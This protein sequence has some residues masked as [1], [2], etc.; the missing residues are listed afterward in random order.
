MPNDVV[1]TM[2]FDFTCE[3]ETTAKSMRDEIV[4]FKAQQ[5]NSILS[6]LLSEKLE[7]TAVWK[8]NKIEIDLGNIRLDEIRSDRMLNAFREL[9]SKRIDE[10]SQERKMQLNTQNAIA[11]LRE[12]GY[13]QNATVSADR[14][15]TA[16][17]IRENGQDRNATAVSLGENQV[18]IIRELL[19]NGDL[20]WWVDKNDFTGIDHVMKTLINEYPE[21]LVSFLQAYRDKAGLAHRMRLLFSNATISK[22]NAILP[23]A[24]RIPPIGTFRI[25]PA[26]GAQIGKLSPKNIEKV[27]HSLDQRLSLRNEHLVALV[28]KKLLKVAGTN[29]LSP[30]KL[31]AVLNANELAALEMIL[32]KNHPLSSA[33]F[34]HTREILRR[35]SAVQLEFLSHW[36]SDAPVVAGP[37][38]RE[39]VARKKAVLH[40]IKS[41]QS[42]GP[43]LQQDLKKLPTRDLL[44]IQKILAAYQQPR[45]ARKKLISLLIEHPYFPRYDLLSLVTNLSLELPD[46]LVLSLQPANV[47]LA[48]WFT[49]SKQ[50]LEASQAA[51][52]KVISRLSK[53]EAIV[54]NEVFSK[55]SI[56]T[57]SARNAVKGVLEK[58]PE[59]CLLLMSVLV[60]LEKS[61]IE[62]LVERPVS[63][64]APS[65]GPR[66]MIVE[67]AGLCLVAPFLPSLF[68]QLGFI[69]NG[70]FKSDSHA[71]RAMHVLQ[72]LVNGRR[73]NYE[74]VMQL[75]RVLCGMDMEEP[76]TRS[77]K[78]LSVAE[79]NEADDLLNSVIEHWKVLKSTSPEGF[80][81]SFL[82]RKGLLY[83]EESQWKLQVEKKGYDLLLDSI[84]WSFKMIKF[85][86]MNKMMDVE[87]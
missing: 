41:L 71:R 75:N 54:L 39:T 24:T 3:T 37:A 9:L 12:N 13:D 5:F 68:D 40:I 76:V 62:K 25:A 83:E 47:N 67:N 7:D 56:T 52:Q 46:D 63:E 73:R 36:V 82:Q 48:R 59:K 51:L 55:G 28:V 66:K 86:W 81:S 2:L 23:S 35:L 19:L 33:A 22:L 14:N 38:P 84:P 69:K 77:Y 44:F 79:R 65:T 11:P 6:D 31:L 42:P 32:T 21:A 17:K 87:W 70:M 60:Q 49:A 43:L 80:R 10:I 74:H 30:L 1:N 26:T 29:L 8:I 78:R 27:V 45:V 72:Y 4:H 34:E 85:S 15:A 53:R 16:E 64:A 18:D 20:P 58:L 61:E 57:P 50:R